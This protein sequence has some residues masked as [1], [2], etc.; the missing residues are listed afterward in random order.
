MLSVL[1]TGTS[2][3]RFTIISD[4]SPSRYHGCQFGWDRQSIGI[5]LSLKVILLRN[6]D[7]FSTTELI[8]GCDDVSSFARGRGDMLGWKGKEAFAAPQSS[9][10]LY[11]RPSKPAA[12][13]PGINDAE[14][15]VRGTQV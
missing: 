5:F 12:L 6:R 4:F 13:Q 2:K 3:L 14:G 10:L 8:P 15:E 1:P 9:R 11:L 7:G